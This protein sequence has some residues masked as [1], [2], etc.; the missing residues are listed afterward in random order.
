MKFKSGDK[1]KI[2]R[3]LGIYRRGF[4]SLINIQD[5]KG[6]L[7]INIVRQQADGTGSYSICGY[8]S[9]YY[10]RKLDEDAEF[11]FSVDKPQKFKLR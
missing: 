9:A 2:V 6:C 3:D 7:I 5:N 4:S 11:S 1:I 8:N 10:F